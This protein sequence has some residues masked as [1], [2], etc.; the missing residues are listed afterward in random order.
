M[1]ISLP[2]E[3]DQDAWFGQLPEEILEHILDHLPT[4][5]TMGVSRR[6]YHAA[7]AVARKGINRN[8]IAAKQFI[9]K[10]FCQCRESLNR[11]PYENPF[12]KATS[13]THLKRI[14]ADIAYKLALEICIAIPVA[15]GLPFKVHTKSTQKILVLAKSSAEIRAIERLSPAKKG[16]VIA[17]AVENIASI[18]PFLATYAVQKAIPA[19]LHNSPES[20]MR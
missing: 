6:W 8:T 17:K 16:K 19:A 15:H 14:E 18:S 13:F 12:K 1:T 5:N 3:K 2:K 7:L 10:S 11:Y 20:T 9:A 4:K